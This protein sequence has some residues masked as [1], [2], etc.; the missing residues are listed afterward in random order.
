[1][2]NVKYFCCICNYYLANTFKGS[3]SFQDWSNPP[4]N[5][6]S[7]FHSIVVNALLC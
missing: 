3:P 4:T 6:P 1:M 5:N 2:F 7:I